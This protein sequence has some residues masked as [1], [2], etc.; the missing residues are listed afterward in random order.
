M[1]IKSGM[2]QE[3]LTLKSFVGSHP[4]NRICWTGYDCLGFIWNIFYFRSDGVFWYFLFICF[5]ALIL[6]KIYINLNKIK[7]LGCMIPKAGGEYEYLMVAFSP[8]YGFLFIWAFVVC[9]YLLIIR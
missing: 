2:N 9:L 7:E 4:R 3:H 1:S 6:I 5:H 8:V